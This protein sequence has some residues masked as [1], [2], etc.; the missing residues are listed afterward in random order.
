MDPGVLMDDIAD[1]MRDVQDMDTSLSD[2]ARA[3]IKRFGWRK[4]EKEKPDEGDMI[5][6]SDGTRRWMDIYY[7]AVGQLTWSDPASG[8]SRRIA[9]HW[10]PVLDLP[11]NLQ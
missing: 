1:A 3:A 6:A 9:T 10:H 8:N 4:L 7:A 11:S 5:I 2:Y